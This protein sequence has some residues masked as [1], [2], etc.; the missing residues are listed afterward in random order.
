MQRN[1][2]RGNQLAPVEPKGY[3]GG[4]QRARR[5]GWGLRNTYA[6][7][8]LFRLSPADHQTRIE[9]AS[10]IADVHPTKK[11]TLLHSRRRLLPKYDEGMHVESGLNVLSF[12]LLVADVR[13]E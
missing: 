9:L 8:Q 12:L 10:D 4:R 5:G 2:G 7:S 13:C 3:R 6:A 11:V 1:Q